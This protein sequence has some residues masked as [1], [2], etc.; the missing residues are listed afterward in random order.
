MAVV[1][2]NPTHHAA[3]AA[4]AGAGCLIIFA[5]EKYTRTVGMTTAL[6]LDL[7]APTQAPELWNWREQRVTV[8]I[9]SSYF[10]PN[11]AL[12][13]EAVGTATAAF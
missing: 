10:P 2:F 9:L 5:P 7:I 8:V 11:H 4:Q 3:A 12:R 6:L 13:D 1:I